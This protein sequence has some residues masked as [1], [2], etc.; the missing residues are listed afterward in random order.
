MIISW[1][2]RP[3][4]KNILCSFSA[5]QKEGSLEKIW[6]GHDSACKSSSTSVRS[7][8]I[9]KYV[10][11]MKLEVLQHKLTLP[12]THFPILDLAEDQEFASLLSRLDYV[13]FLAFSRLQ[14]LHSA[15][16]FWE[17]LI[18][19]DLFL[20]WSNFLLLGTG[21]DLWQLMNFP[22]TKNLSSFYSS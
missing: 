9:K 10:W 14:K 1:R 8:T 19:L 15:V 22:K 21:L 6:N 7:V 17:F 12:F 18:A 3:L 4:Q 20:G 11:K 13:K 5:N 16:V 2:V